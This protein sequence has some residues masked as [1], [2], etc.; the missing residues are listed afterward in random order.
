[1]SYRIGIDLDGV[2]ADFVEGFC[3]LAHRELNKEVSRTPDCWEW[4][5][6]FLT[7][8]DQKV[9]WDHIKSTPG[10]W[11]TLDPV[12]KTAE[13][14]RTLKKWT[15]LDYDLY[16]ITTRPG[17]GVQFV[18]AQWI[19]FEFDIPIPVIITRNAEDKGQVAAALRLTHFVDDNVDN[20]TAVFMAVPTA[21][22][23]LFNATHNQ[24]ADPEWR[25]RRIF[26][27]GDLIE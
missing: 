8:D 16:A 11:G 14:F 23:R 6:Q 13:T 5:D 3:D 21:R 1:M 12:D 4:A 25:S 9:L 22:V 17:L 24:G 2:L 7:K 10:W 15:N 18:T 26:K 20:C 19:L 27:L